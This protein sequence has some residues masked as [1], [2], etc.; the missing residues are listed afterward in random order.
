MP[1]KQLSANPDVDEERA[2]RKLFIAMLGSTPFKVVL[3]AAGAVLLALLTMGWTGYLKSVVA[4]TD[5]VKQNKVQVATLVQTVSEHT[6]Q[7]NQAKVEA[8]RSAELQGKIF[9]AIQ[10]IRRDV[11]SLELHVA[12]VDQKVDDLK[13]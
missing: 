2:D 12:K 1:A 5:D 11:Q 3:G 7:F 6:A 4:E 13:K 8:Q 9:E 10:G